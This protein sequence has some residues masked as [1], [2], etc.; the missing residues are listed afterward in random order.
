MFLSI[1]FDSHLREVAGPFAE[2]KVDEFSI[3]ID[4]VYYAE[5][6]PGEWWQTV[7]LGPHGETRLFDSYKITQEDPR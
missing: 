7:E 5:G 1:Y 2:I 4:E 6:Q 3:Y